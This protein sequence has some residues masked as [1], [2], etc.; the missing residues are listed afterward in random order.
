MGSNAIQLKVD[1]PIILTYQLF[2][3]ATD[4]YVRCHLK[5]Y[6]GVTISGSPFDL[7]HE[8]DGKYVFYD[9][10]NLKFP[11]GAIQLQ[12]QY[13][14]YDD[15]GYSVRSKRQSLGLDIFYLDP[16][17]SPTISIEDIDQKLDQ[18]IN[19]LSSTFPGAEIIG[20]VERDE[21][22]IGIITDE[23]INGLIFSD[24]IDGIIDD[25]EIVG[26]VTNSDISGQI[27]V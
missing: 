16:T 9:I 14:V 2:D 17:Q 21:E 6:D 24:E 1:D 18:I 12:A 5:T 15:A 7:N 26:Y 23:E 25:Q 8:A 27:E 19:V 20:L 3:G 4:K 11:S 13:I 22:I 10:N